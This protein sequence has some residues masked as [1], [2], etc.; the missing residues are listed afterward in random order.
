[1]VTWEVICEFFQV[2]YW[3]NF[4]FQAV[5]FHVKLTYDL[6]FWKWS[7]VN[8]LKEARFLKTAGST[9][10]CSFQ[11]KSVRNLTF[12]IIY[13]QNI[14]TFCSPC[15][16]PALY[17]PARPQRLSKDKKGR[18]GKRVILNILHSGRSRNV[19]MCLERE[20]SRRLSG[21]ELF[22]TAIAGY[23]I[24]SPAASLPPHT[25]RSLRT[26]LHV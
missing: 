19:C 2:Q 14:H 18:G 6:E 24:S 11:G 10:H 5:T 15:V 25:I 13:I 8:V 21:L 7:W 9:K 20:C 1:M 12:W 22:S 23:P 26:L 17:F 3:R 4:V 16:T